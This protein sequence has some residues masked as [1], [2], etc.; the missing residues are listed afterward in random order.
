MVVEEAEDYYFVVGEAEEDCFVV[1]EVET[2]RWMRR[3]RVMRGLVGGF[4]HF[5]LR[6][7]SW[8]VKMMM[9]IAI[10]FVSW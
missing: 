7:K 6:R 8:M 2:S 4:L 3:W 10:D 9:D 1:G 5:C